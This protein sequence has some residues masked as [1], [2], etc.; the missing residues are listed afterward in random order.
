MEIILI[1]MPFADINRPSIG[2]TQLQYRLKCEQGL[3][4][5]ILYLNHDF[6]TY[7]GPEVYAGIADQYITGLGDWLFR[8]IAFPDEPDNKEKYLRRHFPGS[9]PQSIQFFEMLL[10]KRAGLDA[11]LQKLIDA[12]GLADADLVGFTSMFSQNGPSLALANKLKSIK[13]EIVTVMGGANCE[14]PMGQ[15][16]AQ[17]A[18]QL[19]FAFS[20]PALISFPQWVGHRLAGDEDACHRVPGVFSRQ[21]VLDGSMRSP[22]GVEY[23]INNAIPIDYRGFVESYDRRFPALKHD[24]QLIFETSRGCW[25]GERSHCTFCGLNG[26]SMGY[27]QMSAENAVT[28]FNQLFEYVDDFKNFTCVDNILPKNYIAEVFPKL[29]P[30]EGIEIFYEVKA[31]LKDEEVKLLSE[32]R[33]TAVQPGIEAMNTSTLKLM[34]KGTSAFGN[35]GFLKSCGLYGVKP[36]WNLLV[37]FPGEEESVFS[38]YVE[39]IPKLVH[40]P[41]PSDA[42]P[43]RF[44]RFSPYFMKADQF[45]LKLKPYDFYKYIYPFPKESIN[46]LAYYFQNNDY[47]AAYQKAMVRWI[48]KLH[49]AVGEWN[50]SWR[51]ANG[52][53]PELY[54]PDPSNRAH[55]VDTRSGAFEKHDVGQIG[56]RVLE[57]LLKPMSPGMLAKAMADEPGF[58]A[59]IEIEKLLRRGLI[60]HEGSRYLSLVLPRKGSASLKNRFRENQRK[61]A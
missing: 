9:D 36:A 15:E 18:P 38:K 27:R 24:K 11:F 53:F 23:P 54:F 19:D 41:P 8:G 20:G 32:K 12:H 13:P 28:M 5:R 50:R 35:I 37:G 45:G 55:I 25:W 48:G 34:K 40:L 3:D 21:N 39:D 14:S 43:V 58:D 30:P 7:F 1:N 61:S 10:E 44:D 57:H 33:V 46:N 51:D 2:L 16:L 56:A 26:D 42:F 31:D 4:A 59:E 52:I 22:V 29:E 60:F 6:G 49:A 47:G 17:H